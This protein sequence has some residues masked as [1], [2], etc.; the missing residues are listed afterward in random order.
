MKMALPKQFLNTVSSMF[1]NSLDK[2]GLLRP[3]EHWLS[4]VKNMDLLFN[5]H[6]PN[7]R[8]LKGPGVTADFTKVLEEKFQ[9]RRLELLSYFTRLRTGVRVR[10]MN[11]KR[12]APK[13]STLRGLRKQLETVF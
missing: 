11:A 8:V 12:L 7:G 13:K 5:Q 10:E 1:T 3:T 2:G 6:H 4:D 9:N